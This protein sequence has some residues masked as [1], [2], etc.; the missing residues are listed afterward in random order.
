MRARR[1][2]ALAFA[3]P[4]LCSSLALAQT[5]PAPEALPPPPPAATEVLP[6]P[7]AA[8]PEE[9]AATPAPPPTAA[10][11]LTATQVLA[12][13]ATWPLAQPAMQRAMTRERIRLLNRAMIG[14]PERSR[15]GRI[16][17]GVLNLVV[18]GGLIAL[19]FVLTPDAGGVS[20]L[21]GLLW[22]QGSYSA[23]SGTVAL[24]WTPARERLPPRYLE[25]PVR[26]AA[27]RRARV[28][29]G[30][31]ALDDMA[32]D[33]RLRRTLMGVGSSVLGLGT[34]AI[35]Y[36]DQIFDGAPLPTPVE[37]NYLVIGLTAVS[38]AANLITVFTQTEEERL[39]EVYRQELRLLREANED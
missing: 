21:Q 39:R 2:L 8:A 33:A 5:A 6:P 16:T 37:Y 14:L 34:L 3:V 25:L 26:T 13:G 32:R 1:P 17:E 4:M 31:E 38:V 30:E 12:P 9:A 27:E 36:R 28:H 11:T 18:G 10:P 24:A 35:L 20:P 23:L 19:G 29:F 22:F 7:P 15:S